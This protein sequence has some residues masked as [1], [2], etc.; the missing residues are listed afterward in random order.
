LLQVTLNILPGD[1]TPIPGCN[2]G[3]IDLVLFGYPPGHR[4]GFFLGRRGRGFLGR[5]NLGVFR[6][7]RDRSRRFSLAVPNRGTF[8]N[9]P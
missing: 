9:K 5:R 8:L 1:T 7:L 4:G 3:K 2:L 6:G